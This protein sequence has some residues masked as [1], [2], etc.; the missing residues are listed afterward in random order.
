[1]NLDFLYEREQIHR[2]VLD[3]GLTVILKSDRRHALVSTQY[4]VKTG[5]IHEGR[6]LGSGISHYLEHMMF[7]G[8]A[9]RNGREIQE[10]VHLLGGYF[11]AYTSFDRTVY[12]IDAPSEST[13][14]M[15]EI[16]SDMMQNPVF[17]EDEV[18][19]E[20]NV[21][22]REI[23]MR[24]DDPDSVLSER[25]FAT[26]FRV[27]PYQYPIIGYRDLF[28]Q[29]KREDLVEYY[30]SR[31]V[32]NNM[33]LVMVGDFDVEQTE[34]KIRSLWEGKS[35]GFLADLVI[36]D[37]PAVTSKRAVHDFGDYQITRGVQVFSIPGFAHEDSLALRVLADI[38]GSGESSILW[39]ELRQKQKLVHEIY[40]S[41]WNTG[42]TGLFYIRFVAD[43]DKK[44]EALSALTSVLEKVREGYG[45]DDEKVAQVVQK[46][47]AREIRSRTHI[48]GQASML[49][50][51]EYQT[52]DVYYSR[53]QLA[54]LQKV[55]VHD[56]ARV[57]SIWLDGSR[58]L[59]LTMNP[60][61]VRNQVK[62]H[63]STAPVDITVEQGTFSN[64]LRWVIL[65]DNDLPLVSMA[66]MGKG[67]CQ[68]TPSGQ[69]GIS[70]L[71][72]TLLAKDTKF[73]SEEQIVRTVEG[74]AG[75]F[76]GAS[77]NNTFSLV[78]SAL[79]K[80][81]DLMESLLLEGITAPLFKPETFEIEKQAQLSQLREEH[82]DLLPWSL[83]ELRKQFYGN[84]SYGIA[85]EGTECSVLT[86]Q[87]EHAVE[88]W[89][90][91]SNPRNGVLLL[92]GDIADCTSRLKRIE[93]ALSSFGSTTE[94][95]AGQEWSPAAYPELARIKRDRQQAIVMRAFPGYGIV[96]E[97]EVI[98]SVLTQILSGM[99]SHLFERVREEKGLAY[100]VRAS[101][102]LA[103]SH[104]MFYFY[105]GTQP[106]TAQQVLD[107][108][109]Y[110]L[111]RLAS[112]KWDE[113]ELRGAQASLNAG[114][115]SKQQNIASRVTD[116]GIRA[117]CELPLTP[118]NGYQQRI[119]Q[120]VKQDIAQRAEMLLNAPSLSMI[121]EP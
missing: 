113:N 91:M 88:H 109:Q 92:A 14:R 72:A 55:S 87:P 20:R 31:Y 121:V 9:S 28:L 15:L 18:E 68:G 17:P 16:L 65:P 36:P 34:Q 94:L 42:S 67:G 47:Y 79:S 104:G 1:M 51:S 111:E 119:Q 12:Y 98:D 58:S 2:I 107:E 106:A 116:A 73:R 78:C 118:W 10:E 120:V 25:L 48:S 85:S 52:G 5:S 30:Q 54:L 97:Q 86:L 112:G 83:S 71:T 95:P 77:G 43:P 81:I 66:Y 7:K 101:R 108:Y 6:F 46:A 50:A 102:L 62:R 57:A 21:I 33:I 3:N 117:L 19:R 74:V 29:L 11:N 40:A 13:E 37:E 115:R 27:H 61:S 24:D 80:D 26:A 35:R 44:D 103:P 22:L 56:V 90:R 32:P 63:K 41:A 105:A 69:E 49:G 60:E 84:H 8:T 45:L 110:E 64:G 39:Q 99:G 75:N 4:W 38:V 100:Y 93:Q 82:D 70:S 96:H 23:D 89:K 114:I 59:T 53:N 76:Y